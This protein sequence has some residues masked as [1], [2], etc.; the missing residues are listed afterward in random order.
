VDFGKDGFHLSLW[1]FANS[2]SQV[3]LSDSHKPRH[4]RDGIAISSSVLRSEKHVSRGD[5]PAKIAR[6][7]DAHDRRNPALV[8][9]V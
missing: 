6:Q 4:I 7:G 2:L 1:D 3:P 8:Q 9:R 5:R